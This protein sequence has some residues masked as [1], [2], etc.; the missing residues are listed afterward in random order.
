MREIKT[1][2]AHLVAAS[3]RSQGL[4]RIP[5]LVEV[6]A[7][8]RPVAELLARDEAGLAEWKWSA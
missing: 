4:P 8:L 2:I 6:E 3:R 5:G 7:I 1:D